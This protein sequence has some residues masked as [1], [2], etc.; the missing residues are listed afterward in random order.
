MALTKLHSDKIHVSNASSCLRLIY[1]GP[2]IRTLG[3]NKMCLFILSFL[4]PTSPR[5]FQITSVM[6]TSL[7]F[8]WQTPMTLNGVLTGYQLSCQPLLPGIPPPQTLTP[9]HTAVVYMVS[10]LYPGVGYNCSLVARNSAGPSDPAY[11]SGTTQETGVYMY[12]YRCTYMYLILC[13]CVSSCMAL[14][15]SVAATRE[16]I[17]WCV[18]SH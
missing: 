5:M 17:H 4:A 2:L 12:I 14:S 16:C 11:I 6:T 10:A 18:M 8:S 13:C 15:Q 9:G 7:S 3:C 1:I